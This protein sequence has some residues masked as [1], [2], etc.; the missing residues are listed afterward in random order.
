MTA[1]PEFDPADATWESPSEFTALGWRISPTEAG[2]LDDKGASTTVRW[3]REGFFI[4]G[5]DTGAAS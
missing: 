2:T 4:L 1:E 5:D 3:T